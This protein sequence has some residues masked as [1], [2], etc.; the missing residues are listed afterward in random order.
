[1]SGSENYSNDKR[2]YDLNAYNNL[3]SETIYEQL[4]TELLLSKSHAQNL[5]IVNQTL[6]M[7]KEKLEK[8][9]N[10]FKNTPAIVG[11]ISEI[12]HDKFKAVVR[13]NNG[14]VFYV[15][16]PEQYFGK[17]NVDDRVVMAQSNLAILD[18]LPPEKDYRALAF[19]ISDKPKQNLKDI[20]GLKKVIREIEETIIL[21]STKPELFKKFGIES[22]KGVLLYGPPGT[23]KTLLAKA[24]ASKTK[25]TFISL[26]G[27][28]LVHKFIGEG[29]K[30]VKDLFVL[31]KEK[32]PTVIF[33]DE[34]DSVCA[35]RL[36]QSTGADR[37]VNRTMTQLL[38]EMDGFYESEGIKVIAATNRIDILD[39]AILRP[40][41][42]DRIIEVGLP[43]AKERKEI[44]D[45]Y[46]NKMPLGKLNID[47]IV[48]KTE[49]ASGAEIKLI[50][51]ES[52]IFA[53]RK[54]N[55]KI[56]Q[57]DVL[58]AIEKILNN[59]KENK[60]EVRNYFR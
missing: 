41:R 29:A 51:K 42:F 53:I 43:D 55:D 9:L 19:E 28:E 16:I 57:D 13:T 2:E 30:V 1:M 26:S 21:P 7:E 31:A 24:I 8:H 44:F 37:E 34:I 54:N 33:I 11:T 6:A 47:E 45:I 35:Y 5:I 4:K 15:N 27:S 36:D 40:G 49:N 22:P 17:L 12:F 46:L 39:A 56:S 48:E 14:M 3:D 25:S 23:G 50:C 32:A 59:E 18:A 10:A 52:A 60:E 38:V 58:E 20:G